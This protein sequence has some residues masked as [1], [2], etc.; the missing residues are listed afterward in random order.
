MN[1]VK[2]MFEKY[3]YRT[4]VASAY[5][6]MLSGHC[7]DLGLDCKDCDY[8]TMTTMNKYENG[9]LKY[10]YGCNNNKLQRDILLFLL[11]NEANK[12]FL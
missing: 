3:Q 7:V 4:E 11:D 2:K 12:I 9:E 10:I 8:H 6:S 1:S 5:H